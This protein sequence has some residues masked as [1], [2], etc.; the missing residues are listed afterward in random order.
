MGRYPQKEWLF[1]AIGLAMEGLSCF[2]VPFTNTI[3]QLILPLSTIC[4][5]IALIDTSLLP[6]LGYLVDTRHVSVYGSVY[7]IADISYSLAYAFGPIIAGEIVS[8]MGFVALNIIICVLNLAYTP[9]LALL[10]QVYLYQPFEHKQQRQQTVL[11]AECGQ[12]ISD[13]NLP[14]TTMHSFD[15]PQLQNYGAIQQQQFDASNQWGAQPEYPA[16][17]SPDDPLNVQW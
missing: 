5:G 15:M 14:D 2:A 10:R 4:F 17:Y 7:A 6:M 13:A 1:A 11:D 12:L 9:V 3:L 8:T 16:G